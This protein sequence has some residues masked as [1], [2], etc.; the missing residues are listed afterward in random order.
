MKFLLVDDDP[1]AGELLSAVLSRHHYGVELATDGQTGF[2]LAMHY[3]YALILLDVQL[4]QMDGIRLCRQL[5]AQGCQTPILMLTGKDASEDIVAGLDAGADDYVTKPW[6][7]SQLIARIR[8]LLRRSRGTMQ[9]VCLTW[10]HLSLDTLSAQVTYRDRV[11]AL[12]PKEYSLL[13]LFLQ[14]PQRF[15]TRSVIID[16]LWSM[17]NF[18]S[19][20]AVTNLIKDL[21]RRLRSV[22]MTEEL[23]E[24]VY[25]LG[26]RLNTSPTTQ[27]AALP[28]N[29][30]NSDS[31]SSGVEVSA[32][33][34]EQLVERYR[35]SLQQRVEQ[36]EA[37]EQAYRTATLTLPQQR[38]A[39]AE[40][41]KL[42]GSL[43]TYG[44]QASSTMARAIEHL[45]QED[46]TLNESQGT[47]FSQLLRQLKQTLAQ[48]Q[49]TPFVASPP[50][51][52]Q[53][54]SV[55]LVDG[56]D[57]DLNLLNALQQAAPAWVAMVVSL[58]DRAAIQPWLAQHP[59]STVV[60]RFQGAVA[61]EEAALIRDIKQQFPATPV[62][63]LIEQDGLDTRLNILHSGSERC[64]L[65]PFTADHI[66]D[67]IA[68]VLPLPSSKTAKVLAVDDDPVILQT[69]ACLLEPRGLQ[70]QSLE[71]P[72]QFWELFTTLQP[73]LLL[74]DLELPTV[75]GLELCRMVRQDAH[76]GDI[77]IL[78]ITAHTDINSIQQVFAAGADDFVGKPISGP[79]LV[80]RVLS[81]IQRSRL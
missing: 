76:Y 6:E 39:K 24:T 52:Q 11:V 35:L 45:L 33:E 65:Q 69:L 55:L 32:D 26:Y 74:L 30:S 8:A 2:D 81:R 43:G 5:R 15:F 53:Q 31:S 38:Q 44:Y 16:H 29:S 75:N 10:G 1:S 63:T 54:V 37:A 42:A 23:I 51:M 57:E 14:H 27:V 13:E 46:T 12:R 73:N 60:F 40:A 20:S 79:E 34:I 21:R 68:Q 41:H 18:P 47:Q 56:G 62:V 22:G 3:E 17:D 4:P 28:A 59:L 49:S 50:P 48:P 64:L 80:S 25:G 66:F 77:P 67:A 36:L 71:N 58:R 61:T 72:C 78:V 7:A 9:S 19:E 70:I